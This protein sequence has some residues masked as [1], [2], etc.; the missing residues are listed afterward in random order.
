MTII[1]FRN[2]VIG[3]VIAHLDI[4]VRKIVMELDRI[5]CRLGEIETLLDTGGARAKRG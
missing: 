2:K 4:T 3:R 5:N 1:R